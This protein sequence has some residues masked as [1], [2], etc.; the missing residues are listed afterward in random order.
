VVSLEC[1][2]DV[3]VVGAGYAGVTAAR[4]LR[5]RGVTVL[6]LEGR[7][8]VG[9]RTYSKKFK[10]R[11]ELMEF[12]GAWFSCDYMPNMAREVERYHA[13]LMQS[14]ELETYR[15][16]VRGR[17]SEFPVPPDE[18]VPFERAWLAIANAAARISTHIP[19]HMQKLA[20]LDVSWMEFLA[21][22]ELPSA[23][24]QFY[25]TAISTYVGGHPHDFS[26]LHTLGCI[27]TLGRSPYSAFHGVLVDK[28]A[29]GTADILHRMIEGSAVELRLSTPV[30]AVEHDAERVTVTTEHGDRHTALACVLA[31]PTNTL[32]RIR[33]TPELSEKK[34][35]ATARI[36][37]GRGYRVNMLVEG[38]PPN[39]FGLGWGGGLQMLLTEYQ[40]DDRHSLLSGFGA[41]SLHRLDPT[42]RDQVQAAVDRFLEGARVLE[43]DA[44]DYN[45]D[46]FSDGTW[47]INPPG[48]TRTFART[49]N[50]PEG[51]LYFAGSD[52]SLSLLNGWM[53]GAVHSG[54]RAAERICSAL[55]LS[56]VIRPAG[57]DREAVST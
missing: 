53:E 54:H 5:D 55:G 26:A 14:P 1:E 35:E 2:Y 40:L 19:P 49:M 50:E 6:L 7:D 8:R 11:H 30:T 39:L 52:V 12:G 16:L 18:L 13:R 9:G 57:G 44:H 17:V 41:E 25:L 10:G 27:A 23:T 4:D 22:L 28:F 33:I 56:D 15:F 43:V 37:P 3:V 47:R 31:V 46:P 20:D 51:R 42:N 36:H 38:A 24:Y 21:P 32:R 45:D 29:N 34:R 48:E